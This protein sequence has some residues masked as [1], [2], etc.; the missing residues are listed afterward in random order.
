MPFTIANR[1]DRQILTLEGAVT[2]RDAQD[3][4]A[5]LKEDLEDGTQLGIDTQGLEDIDTC[6]LQLL[7]SLRKTVS[8][9]SFDN[10]SEV[11]IGAVERCGL[12]RELLSAREGL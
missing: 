8:A 2:I 1:Q 12:R 5:R 9:L 11:F 7:C 3:L 10:P 6:I 4:A